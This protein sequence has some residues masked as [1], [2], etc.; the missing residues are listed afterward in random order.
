MNGNSY[1][2]VEEFD[3]RCSEIYLQNLNI[4]YNSRVALQEFAYGAVVRWSKKSKISF[5]AFQVA[6]EDAISYED[7]VEVG[8]AYSIYREDSIKLKQMIHL[9]L[10]SVIEVEEHY[11]ELAPTYVRT[12]PNSAN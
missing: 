6:M 10:V 1:H 12:Q 4:V 11:A 8:R 2:T 5:R 7:D 9:Y 3:H